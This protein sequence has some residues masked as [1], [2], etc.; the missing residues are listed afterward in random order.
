MRNTFIFEEVFDYE[1]GQYITE[2]FCHSFLQC[3]LILIS[4]F[5]YTSLKY[6]I[7]KFEKLKSVFRLIL[8]T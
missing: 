2:V 5:T 7:S 8:Y 4:Y 1:S 6:C 3:F